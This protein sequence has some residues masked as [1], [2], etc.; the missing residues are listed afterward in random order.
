MSRIALA[1]ALLAFASIGVVTRS[2]VVAAPT[3][4]SL[5]VRAVGATMEFRTLG[6]PGF[7]FTLRDGRSK[8]WTGLSPG[9]YVVVQAPP[10]GGGLRIQCSDGVSANQYNL[11]AGQNL[12]CTFIA[13]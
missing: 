11:S 4:A 8:T 6:L 10:W 9:R 12:T 2:S 13:E 7:K 3:T 1:I 5:H